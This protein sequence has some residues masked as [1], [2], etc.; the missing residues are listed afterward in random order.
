MSI[1]TSSY[2]ECSWIPSL[3]VELFINFRFAWHFSFLQKVVE[4]IKSHLTHSL[5]FPSSNINFTDLSLL[6]TST[7]DV[8]ILGKLSVSNLLVQGICTEIKVNL[9]SLFVQIQVNALAISCI[10][11]SDWNNHDLTW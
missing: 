6:L 8:V 7:N 1:S 4:F 10:L 9:I 11:G 2:L 3:F 5:I